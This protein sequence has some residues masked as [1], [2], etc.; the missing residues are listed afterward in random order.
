MTVEHVIASDGKVIPAESL[1][2]TYAYNGDGTMNYIQV[3]WDGA[4]Y[5][6]TFTYSAGAVTGVSAW[7]KQ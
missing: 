2:Q 6:Q 5:R 3:A 1:A 4:T 7:V